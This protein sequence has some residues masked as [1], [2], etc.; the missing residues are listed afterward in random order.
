MNQRLHFIS[1]TYFLFLFLNVA[2]IVFITETQIKNVALYRRKFHMTLS[3][4]L[5]KM[6]I[7]RKKL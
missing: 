1:F 3:F 7:A 2:F 4:P 5:E 6:T